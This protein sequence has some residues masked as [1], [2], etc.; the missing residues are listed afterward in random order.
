MK[1][2]NII[3]MLSAAL[4]LMAACTD[5]VLVR[6]DDTTDTGVTLTMTTKGVITKA[7]DGAA[8]GYENATPA[9]IK[10]HDVAIA[11]F[12]GEGE[13]EQRVGFKYVS[14]QDGATSDKVGDK[15]CYVVKNI[16]VQ[17]GNNIT[18]LVLA[19]S[20]LS[21]EY[22]KVASA[23]KES[24]KKLSTS[25]TGNTF[26]ASHLIKFGEKTINIE[27][28]KSVEIPIELTQLAARIDLSFDVKDSSV[29][30]DETSLWSFDVSEVQIANVA[31]KSY[32]F[33]S[34]EETAVN[35]FDNGDFVTGQF[36][37]WKT[38]GEEK[39]VK[40]CFYTYE[41]NFESQDKPI[42]I[43]VNGD[44]YL[45]E[46]KQGAS[47][48][49]TLSFN[50]KKE[51][52]CTTNGIVHGNL[53][54]L[55]GTIDAKTRLME[56]AWTLSDWKV[57][58]RNVTVEIIQ[59]AFLVV[60]DLEMTMPNITS[61]STTFQSSSVIKITDVKVTNG[62]ANQKLKVTFIPA[63]SSWSDSNS[64]TIKIDS[65]LPIN[66]V[67]KQIT[68]T[69]INK[70]GISQDIL[71]DQYPY[72]YVSNYV[73][74]TSASGGSGQNNSK[75]YIFKTLIADYSALQNETLQLNES[76]TQ[77]SWE[78]GTGHK[79]SLT[80]RETAGMQTKSD[81]KQAVVGYPKVESIYFDRVDSKQNSTSE[82]KH[83]LNRNID[84]TVEGAEN[85]YLISPCFILASQVGVNNG[86]TK[87]TSKEFCAGYV[88]NDNSG[89][90][91][92]N[93]PGKWRVPT[94][95]ELQLID[96]LQNI[97]VCDVKKILEGGNYWSAIYS[98]INFMD[99]RREG[100]NAVRCVRDI[101]E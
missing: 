37:L 71:I 16:L 75:M 48:E 5:E 67:P 95:A 49:Y 68:F 11:F 39:A 98:Q 8:D 32:A 60:A 66:F 46:E 85:N 34:T 80:S 91:S 56:F 93:S 96:I 54:E 9:E 94:K 73:S 76:W 77:S 31:R 29:G 83:T 92:D 61:V 33:M 100:T 81:L 42:T 17:G 28:G 72:L 20:S 58:E 78:G 70:E 79:G 7:L 38:D 19:N 40:F 55:V 2:R 87:T 13:E 1:L 84:C 99:P 14:F 4:L 6:Q 74:K 12:K 65:E 69:V 101:K 22:L 21:E 51:G 53:Y 59:P 3:S 97:E 36:S 90:I 63:A 57:R 25:V 27:R 86:K 10:I 89:N 62:S 18:V 64:G 45:G 24:F 47:R 88:E 52:Q 35:T 15:D 50:P 43:T 30:S 44:L 26:D 41:K 23:S 82:R